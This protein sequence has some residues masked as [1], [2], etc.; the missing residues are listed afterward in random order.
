MENDTLDTVIPL[1]KLKRDNVSIYGSVLYKIPLSE[2]WIMIITTKAERFYYDMKNGRS[3]WQLPRLHDD[4]Q[5]QM[6][7][8]KLMNIKELLVCLI[9]MIRGVKVSNTTRQKVANMLSVNLTN[10]AEDNKESIRHENDINDKKNSVLD[11]TDFEETQEENE[12]DDVS[13]EFVLGLSDLED[14]VSGSD[15]EDVDGNEKKLETQSKV[16]IPINNPEYLSFFTKYSN[17]SN[18]IQSEDL[19][20][21]PISSII[22]FI[23]IL[24]DSK[25]D[26]FSSYDLE[27]DDLIRIPEYVIHQCHLINSKIQRELWDEYCRIKG[28]SSSDGNSDDNSD[29]DESMKKNGCY[30]ADTSELKFAVYLRDYGNNNNNNNIK[31]IPKFYTDFN[32]QC[33]KKAKV[34]PDDNYTT[35]CKELPLTVRQSIYNKWKD[36][37]KKDENE[38]ES[39]VSDNIRKICKSGE[40]LSD[41]LNTIKG[42]KLIDCFDCFFVDM[43][44][45]TR[46]WNNLKA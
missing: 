29:S 17:L 45:L 42:K 22:G 8:E 43:E 4:N 25:I 3:W 32:R 2:D 7:F 1:K 5:L 28:T 21:T 18:I 41:V 20:I 46:V 14:L 9:G 30:T 11:N 38:K 13:N 44:M 37:V 26:A 19:K 10:F 27:V 34:D 39:I 15:I 24:E 36:F 40:T 35:L 16:E 33:L 31:K 6:A 23:R 12:E